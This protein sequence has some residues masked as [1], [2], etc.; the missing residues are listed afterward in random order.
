MLSDRCKHEITDDE[1]LSF[2][3]ASPARSRLTDGSRASEVLQAKQDAICN[4]EATSS[5]SPRISPCNRCSADR[6]LTD[7]PLL[8]IAV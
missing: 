7:L 4:F 6:A 1:G 3:R 5:L 2:G 8:E